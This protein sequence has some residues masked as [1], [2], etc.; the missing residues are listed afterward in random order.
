M[1]YDA[2]GKVKKIID[3]FRTDFAKT[4]ESTRANYVK[5]LP[6]GA[7]I[8]GENKIF[9]PAEVDAFTGR[10]NKYRQDAT[11][12]LNSCLEDISKKKTESPSSDAVNLLTLMS[13]RQNVTADELNDVINNYGSNYQVYRACQDISVKNNLGHLSDHPLQ[14]KEQSIN[15]LQ[16]NL[17]RLFTYGDACKNASGGFY[18]FM[19]IAVDNALS[20]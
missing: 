4:V 1:V 5:S 15:D 20:E 6:A 8:P 13:A 19:Q 11:D 2:N 14:V 16:N 3:D 12:I 18:S 9:D 17:N 10:A 7:T